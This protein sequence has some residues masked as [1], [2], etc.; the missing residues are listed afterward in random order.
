VADLRYSLSE[1]IPE[2]FRAANSLSLAVD[3]HL[4]G[5]AEEAARLIGQANCPAVWAYIDAAW[6]RGARARYQFLS[7]QNAPAYLPKAERPIPRMPNAAIKAFVKERDQMHCRFCGMP[8]IDPSIRKAMIAE[9]L[10][11]I[12]W[13]RTDIDKHAA[14]TCLWL[15]YDHVLPNSR[16]GDSSAENIVLTCTAC[17]FGRMDTTLEEGRLLHPLE[18]VRPKWSGFQ[19]WDGLERFVHAKGG[20]DA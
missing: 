9:Y 8:V 2:V 17:N 6:G 12:E 10:D 14:F 19:T 3:A 13:P 4:L 11:H 7:I 1:P 5:H 18:H 15:Q 16:G 20:S